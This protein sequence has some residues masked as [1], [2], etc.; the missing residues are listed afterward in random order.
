MK[1]GWGKWCSE[2]SY[3]WRTEARERWFLLIQNDNAFGGS[4]FMRNSKWKWKRTGECKKWAQ[5]K[6]SKPITTVLACICFLVEEEFLRNIE[7]KN[8]KYLWKD[9]ERFCTE[10]SQAQKI[11]LRCQ[12]QQIRLGSDEFLSPFL[13][14]VKS[15]WID[16][17]PLGI[18]AVRMKKTVLFGR[19]YQTIIKIW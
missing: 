17:A 15:I 2:Q 9:L 6:V 18:S 16:S 19:G 12:L 14:R 4:R 7:D 10:Q 3:N 1:Y 13:R 5:V 11:Y 8:L